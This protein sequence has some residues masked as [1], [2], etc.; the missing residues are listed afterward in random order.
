M[1]Q[2]PFVL[3]VIASQQII[4]S[5]QYYKNIKTVNKVKYNEFGFTLLLIF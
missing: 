3:F 5:W 1:T 4:H 2:I